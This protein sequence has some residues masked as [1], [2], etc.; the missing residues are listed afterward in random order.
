MK[1]IV[2]PILF[3]LFGVLLFAFETFVLNL[4]SNVSVGLTN[5]I[6]VLNI[7]VLIAIP[8]FMFY[9]FIIPMYKKMIDPFKKI[10]FLLYNVVAFPLVS[11]YWITLLVWK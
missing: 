10:L 7:I 1:Q 2:F 5:A 9:A 3:F 6:N 11:Y 8:A 4:L